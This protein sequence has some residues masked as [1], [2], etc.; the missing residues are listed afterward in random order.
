[1]LGAVASL[2]HNTDASNDANDYISMGLTPEVRFRTSFYDRFAIRLMLQRTDFHKRSLSPVNPASQVDE[3]IGVRLRWWHRLPGNIAAE[4]IAG[5]SALDSNEDTFDSMTTL[6]GGRLWYVFNRSYRLVTSVLYGLEQFES[7]V[8]AGTQ[9]AR[10][11]NLRIT[12]EISYRVSKQL[13][14]AITLTHSERD[15]NE[16]GLDY[17][18]T[19]S[20]FT[21]TLSLL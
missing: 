10:D 6:C 1:M 3:L 20:Y 9:R 4:A 13:R 18:R 2:I 16:V 12:S 14:F 5:Y 7:F 21:T 11:T 15:S 19:A 8:S 17:T